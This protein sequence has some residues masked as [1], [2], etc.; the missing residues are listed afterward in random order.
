MLTSCSAIIRR[1]TR[2]KHVTL[3]IATVTPL[4]R[5]RIVTELDSISL[6]GGLEEI[7]FLKKIWP[8]VKLPSPSP[9]SSEPTMEDYIFRHRV[10]NPDDMSNTEVLEALG[11]YTCSQKH[12]FRF[13]EVL[14]HPLTRETSE[15]TELVAQLNRHLSHDGYGL[16]EVNSMSG[17]PIYEVRRIERATVMKVS[18]KLALIDRLGR[19]LQAKFRLNEIDVFLAEY[20]I[21]KPKPESVPYNSKWTYSKVALQ[22]V[23]SG[24]LLK[25]AQE[26][27][28]EAPHGGIA[29]SAPPQHWKETSQ[30][31]LFISHIS[32]NKHQATRLK[33][34]LAP[35][36]ISAFVAHEDILP[37]LEW[38]P[39]VERALYFMDAFYCHPYT[40]LF[41]ELLDPTRDRFCRRP[42]SENYLVFNGRGPNRLYI[43]AASLGTATTDSG[44]N[45][46]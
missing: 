29:A 6:S 28:V 3:M 20:R 7:E 12:F 40:R 11:I 44:A 22:G 26:L 43:K 10:R 41:K 46:G 36:A 35:Y 17:S 23:D 1:T 38:Q 5:R 19:A 33:E 16:Q 42:W 8:I 25:I 9:R 13:L 37:T 39:E 32:E 2:S 34:C 18:D 14:V 21:P 27:G 24:I 31:R 45:R 15:Q 4:T 30:F